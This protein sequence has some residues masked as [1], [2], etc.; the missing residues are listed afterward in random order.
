MSSVKPLKTFQNLPPSKQENIIRIALE[1][2]ADKGFNGASINTIVK[3]LGIAK[4]S[5]YQY[6]DD[7]NALFFFVF[8]HSMNQVK[9]FLKNIRDNT[10][11]DPLIDRLKKTL[12]GGV[13]F[14]EAQPLV[15]KLYITILNDWSVPFR[16]EFLL[17]LRSNSLEYMANLLKTAQAK[18]E[19]K[20]GTDI[21][22]ACFVIDAVMDRFLMSRTIPHMS[23]KTGIFESEKPAL[24][25]WISD[26]LNM[27]CHGIA[28]D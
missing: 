6:F 25:S 15:Y 7:K 11:D 27:L 28:H 23:C 17:A 16:E 19:L 22:H 5:I 14:I 18:G 3:K 1:E 2:F 12:E 24:G 20:P 21:N 9:Q 26:I 8:N 4:G 13:D 10:K